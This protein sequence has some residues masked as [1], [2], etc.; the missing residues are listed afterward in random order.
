MY[1]YLFFSFRSATAGTGNEFELLLL[2]RGRRVATCGVHRSP[3]RSSSSGLVRAAAGARTACSGA[4]CATNRRVPPLRALSSLFT[5]TL[6]FLRWSGSFLLVSPPHS[7][8]TPTPPH[9][10]TLPSTARFCCQRR[11]RAGQNRRRIARRAEELRRALRRRGLVRR[12]AGVQ[13]AVRTRRRGAAARAARQ[14][15]PAERHVPAAP[16]VPDRAGVGCPR[17]S[18]AHARSATGGTRRGWR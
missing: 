1:L 3:T 7:H 4:T 17:A 2:R 11:R 8:T 18:H 5:R 13:R 16:Y 14:S 15:H 12:G 10:H 6:L 9:T